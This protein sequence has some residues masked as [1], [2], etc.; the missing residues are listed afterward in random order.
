MRRGGRGAKRRGGRAATL[1]ARRPRPT[2][3][4]GRLLRRCLALRDAL[5][6]LVFVFPR[7][8]RVANHVFATERLEEVFFGLLA[9]E[10]RVDDLGC[11]FDLFFLLIEVGLDVALFA[12]V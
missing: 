10:E 5:A 11:G 2:L 12:V 1:C 4:L 6:A 3:L 9:V 8:V 7:A